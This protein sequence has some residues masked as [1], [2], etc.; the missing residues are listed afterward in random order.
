M[1]YV[2]FKY[3]KSSTL[4]TTK[5][6]QG[7]KQLYLNFIQHAILKMWCNMHWIC[8]TLYVWQTIKIN[9]LI[10]PCSVLSFFRSYILYIVL[11]FCL[12]FCFIIN[13]SCVVLI[14]FFEDIE[15]S[16]DHILSIKGLYTTIRM[17]CCKIIF[18][19][20]FVFFLNQCDF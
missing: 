1:S 4:W 9:F 7:K 10:S 8:Y 20:S 14:S 11:H 15:K 6:P 3:R 5:Y 19:W 17:F 16:T 13:H 12:L 18:E 2:K